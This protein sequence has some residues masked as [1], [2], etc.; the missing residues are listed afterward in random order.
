MNNTRRS[1]SFTSAT[2]CKRVCK[3]DFPPEISSFSNLA[4][5]ATQHKPKGPSKGLASD[6]LSCLPGCLYDL[7]APLHLWPDLAFQTLQ[8]K[9]PEKSLLVWPVL[10][11]MACSMR[12]LVE[13]LLPTSRWRTHRPS[14]IILLFLGKCVL[15]L[16]ARRKYAQKSSRKP[17]ILQL[18]GTNCTYLLALSARLLASYS[19]PFFA[20][21]VLEAHTL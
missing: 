20:G 1:F 6:G 2:G 5:G 9:H 10:K 19:A 18:K 8:A 15:Q 16:G 13:P 3:A 14:F 11:R 17:T 21:L 4:P 7:Y 12:E